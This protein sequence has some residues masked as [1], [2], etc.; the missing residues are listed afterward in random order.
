[1]SDNADELFL[2]GKAA[3]EAGNY[4]DA[5]KLLSK[6]LSWKSRPEAYLVKAQVESKRK[7]LSQALYEVESGLRACEREKSAIDTHIVAKLQLMKVDFENQ[8]KDNESKKREKSKAMREHKASALTSDSAKAFAEKSVKPAI[9]LN[10]GT[11]IE[12]EKVSRLGGIPSVPAQFEWPSWQEGPLEFLCQINLEELS[13]FKTIAGILPEKGMLSFF[14][15][16]KEQPWGSLLSD[17]D[18]FRVYFFED[19]TALT[20]AT[21]AKESSIK[22]AH[23]ELNEIQ[24]YPDTLS[25]DL[26][27]A[28]SDESSEEYSDLLYAVNGEGPH[29]Q[30]LGHPFLVQN[31]LRE[32]C[33]RSSQDL[34]YEGTV[35]EQKSVFDK[36]RDWTLLLQ[37]D[38]SE[39]LNMCWGDAGLIYF[40][41]RKSDLKNADFSKVWL[42]LQC[43]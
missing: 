13:P 11:A 42:L 29:H 22:P 8:I 37:L 10:L 14:Y 16:A 38:S 2:S 17:K 25:D 18:A 5:L 30:L 20:L 24:T 34:G 12:N 26:N 31:D 21:G 6:S 41:I 40:C 1:M 43:T 7:N 36:S 27:D 33:E 39:D 19:I 15:D 35:E 3:Y 4:E 32:D 23:F 28:L 9:R